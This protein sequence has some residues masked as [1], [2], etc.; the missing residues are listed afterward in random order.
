MV[1]CE[2]TFITVR[3]APVAN[4]VYE[5]AGLLTL[6]GGMVRVRDW[7]KDET[8]FDPEKLTRY[9]LHTRAKVEAGLGASETKESLEAGLGPI[10]TSYTAKGQQRVTLIVAYRCQVKGMVSVAP[11]DK[12]VDAATWL[13]KIDDWERFAPGNRLIIAHLRWSRLDTDMQEQAR[14]P[15][16]AAAEQCSALA[17]TMG[18]PNVPVPWASSTELKEWRGGWIAN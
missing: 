9:S 13:S 18:L 2:D 4:E 3:K 17:Q 11:N 16:E 5:F 1:E 15:V 6:P 7:P 10:V 14:A 8:P 12:S